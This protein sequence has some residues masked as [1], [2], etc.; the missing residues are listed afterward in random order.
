MDCESS[1]F[2]LPAG[3]VFVFESGGD[4][5]DLHRV[6]HFFIQ[7]STENDV[8]VFVSGAL[9]DAARLLHLGQLQRR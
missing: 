1:G 6:L 5:R 3:A 4:D 7:H 9:D 2:G 8:G